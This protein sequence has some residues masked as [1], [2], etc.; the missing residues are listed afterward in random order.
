MAVLP[1]MLQPLVVNDRISTLVVINDTLQKAFGTGQG[2]NRVRKHPSRRGLYDVFDETRQI[3]TATNPGTHS[4]SR[5]RFPIAQIP[6]AIP[7]VAEHFLIPLEEVNQSRPLGLP[8]EIDELG[9]QYL[10]DQERNI[11]QET[12][13]LREF[14][15]AAML[16]G[17]YGYT[18]TGDG[19]SH[20][21]TGSTYT[22]NYQ[23]PAGNLSQLDMLGAGDIIGTAWDNAAAPIVR[24]LLAINSAFIELT[25]IGLRD[26]WVT[27]TMWGNIITNTEV[28]N[29]AGSAND[30]VQS[31]VRN[32]E[33]EDA[34]AILRGCPWV[35]FHITDNGLNVGAPGSGFSKL[36]ADTAAVFC[37][38]IDDRILDYYECPEPIVDP[39][40]QQLSNQYGE[41]YYHKFVDDPVAW[42]FHRRFNGL[43]ILKIPKAIAYATV[44]F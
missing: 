13:N 30:P 4:V 23:I 3:P 35:T 31:Y 20:G 12:V 1:T 15:T 44:D 37:T 7:R 25:G 6:Y 33:T 29:L 9:R 5:A 21:F 18:Q 40:T 41:Y 8:S 16:R 10:M 39:V 26:V 27:S 11:K 28:Q 24:D 43:P 42:E 38:R 36:I 14:Q 2:G 19:F 22:V 32:E 34:T 17:S